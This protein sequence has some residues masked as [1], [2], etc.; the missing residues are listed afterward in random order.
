MTIYMH[1]RG[2]VGYFVIRTDLQ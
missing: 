2:G 1:K